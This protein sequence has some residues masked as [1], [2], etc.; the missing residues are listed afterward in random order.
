KKNLTDGKD[1]VYFEF[2]GDDEFKSILKMYAAAK[3]LAD[4]SSS[5]SKAAYFKI[6]GDYEKQLTKWIR[7]NINKCFDI[8][9]K[10]ERRNILNWLK[11]RRLKDRT[12]KEQIDLAASSCLSTYFDELYPDYPQFSIMITS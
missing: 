11:G 7:Q 2:T 4:L 1:E 3:K 6:A 10:G 12:L 8:R 9:Y 5:E